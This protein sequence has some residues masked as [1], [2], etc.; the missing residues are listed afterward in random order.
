VTAQARSYG[1]GR[2]AAARPQRLQGPVTGVQ[3]VLS[4][5]PRRLAARVALRA[6][7]AL[8]ALCLLRPAWDGML[9]RYADQVLGLDAVLCLVACL[10]VTPA[11]TVARLPV[12]KLRFW[13]GNWVFACGLAGLLVH[14][15]V[16]TPGDLAERAAGTVQTWTGTLVVL[17]LLPLAAT[18]SALAQKIL[19]PEWKRW[20]RW[21]TWGVWLLVAVHLLALRAY[22]D[23]GAYLAATLPAI[24]VRRPRVRQGIKEWRAGGYSTGGYWALLAALSLLTLAGLAVLAGQEVQAAARA[25]LL[26]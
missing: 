22:L 15:Y 3:A 19:G 25:A 6:W 16:M 26:S 14:L 12:A 1:R 24:L 23:D 2:H 8:P 13:Y 5:E 4:A 11:I 7:P 10:A 20:Q 18:S 17:L 21:G 9:P